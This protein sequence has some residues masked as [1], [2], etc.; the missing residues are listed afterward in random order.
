MLLGTRGGQRL[1]KTLPHKGF[2]FVGAVREA[3]GSGRKPDAGIS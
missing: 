2:R 1:T 3:Q